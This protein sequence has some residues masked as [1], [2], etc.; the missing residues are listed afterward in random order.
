M[1]ALFHHKLK[2][3]FLSMFCILARKFASLHIIYYLYMCVC[4]FVSIAIA[5]HFMVLVN[6]LCSIFMFAASLFYKTLCPVG[7][8]FFNFRRQ[9]FIQYENISPV[10][11]HCFRFGKCNY[12][13]ALTDS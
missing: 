8:T 2:E 11:L 5:G 10:R 9:K 3:F 4:V 7:K 1:I 12:S 6:Q 13:N